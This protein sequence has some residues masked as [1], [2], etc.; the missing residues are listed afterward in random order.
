MRR[1]ILHRRLMDKC[2]KPETLIAWCIDQENYLFLGDYVDRGKRS[3]ETICLLFAYKALYDIIF[4]YLCIFALSCWGLSWVPTIGGLL[5]YIETM[6]GQ[7]SGELFPPEGQPRVTF[8][9]PDN[10]F[11]KCHLGVLLWDLGCSKVQRRIYGFYDECKSRYNTKIWK[12]FCDLSHARMNKSTVRLHITNLFCSTVWLLDCMQ[13]LAKS[14]IPFRFLEVLGGRT[15]MSKHDKVCRIG[16]TR[17]GPK[18]MYSTTC[19]PVP[20]LQTRQVK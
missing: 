15:K 9:L 14:H 6:S 2:Q 4:A 1:G 19:Q 8:N 11:F 20:S 10:V 5:I 17:V 18:V 12:T 16:R 3:L 7:I 13:H